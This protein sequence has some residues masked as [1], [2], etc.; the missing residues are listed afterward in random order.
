MNK[1]KGAIRWELRGLN[2]LKNVFSLPN[3]LRTNTHLIG[4]IYLTDSIF[5]GVMVQERKGKQVLKSLRMT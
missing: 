5:C 2:P 3:Y 4:S 1:Y